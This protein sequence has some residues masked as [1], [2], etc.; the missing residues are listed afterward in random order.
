MYYSSGCIAYVT[1]GIQLCITKLD[2]IS[3]VHHKLIS[4]K[5]VILEWAV[6]SVRVRRGGAH[7]L[8]RIFGCLEARDPPEGCDDDLGDLYAESGQ[9]LQGSFSAGLKQASKQASS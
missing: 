5:C 9:T 2:R 1:E 4:T 8:H 7:R 6:Q 3:V